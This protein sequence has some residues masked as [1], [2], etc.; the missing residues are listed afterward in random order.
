MKKV[1]MLS[2]LVTTCLYLI[3]C[4]PTNIPREYTIYFDSK[5]GSDVEPIKTD[6]KS[7]IT[8]PE[9]PEKSGYVF[10]GWYWDDETFDDPLTVNSFLDNPISSNMTVYA[11]WDEN[12]E[13]I[14]YFAG[15]K[16]ENTYQFSLTIDA[17]E[18]PNYSEALLVDIKP[19]PMH[20]LAP[21]S[22]TI[23]SGEQGSRLIDG[24]LLIDEIVA[25][26][27]YRYYP[28]VTAGPY[29]FI[30][31]VNQVVTLEIDPLFKGDYNGQLPT[32]E[33]IIQKQ[34]D[35]VTNVQQVINGEI[36]LVAGVIEGAMIEAAEAASTV[37]THY[38]ERNGYGLLAMTCDFG[39]TTDVKVRQAIAHLTDRDYLIQNILEG[40]ASEIYS[41]YSL[42]QWMFKESE[43]WALESLNPYAFNIDAANALLDETI[44]R[45]ESDGET[46]WDKAKA[47]TEENYYRYNSSG[48]VLEIRHFQ[49]EGG[50]NS[51]PVSDR[52]YQ[53]MPL[54]GIQYQGSFGSFDTLIDHYYYGFELGD[55]RIYH[56][57]N[58][59]TNFDNP[60]D[61]Y[62]SWHS[63]LLNTWYNCQGL[64]DED[65]DELMM[66]LRE[67]DPN[68]ETAHADYLAAWRAYQ[69]RW[70][71]LIPS[72]PLYSNQYYQV[73]DISLEGVD[74]TTAFAD[75]SK[76]ICNIN[77][78]ADT[79]DD[80]LIVGVM[81]MNGNYMPGFG[82]NEYDEQIRNLIYGYGT[83]AVTPGG[84]IILNETVVE[85][86]EI[87][88]NDDFSKTYT[89][90][91][92]N[93]LF[94]SDG[95]PITAADFVFAVLFQASN[96]WQDITN[97][98]VGVGLK[99]YEEYR[100]INPVS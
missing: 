57:F 84:E 25:P 77:W 85:D 93:D 14:P 17:A 99:G 81:E 60:Y 23:E 76:S 38:V 80:E 19:L 86:L 68:S 65:L 49:T 61:P 64:D 79:D 41:E 63:D 26:G 98:S 70:N 7:A 52:F 54:A 97:S 75:W 2:W 1:L 51:S 43:Q 94:W 90:T 95:E 28:A 34:V 8:L 4:H 10:G 13:V 100:D 69:V 59:A 78:A 42:E 67:I 24:F 6:G 91:I 16:L 33:T 44:W 3:S 72:V 45:F 46:P 36:D 32:I 88:V 29:K 92:A 82:S 9:D 11:K 53:T 27:G 31:F 56:L 37:G 39:P 5:G 20:V 66:E 83:Y 18:F 71:H 89:F 22:A 87:V 96:E 50:S 74:K 48:E 58:L 47:A 55:E 73:F 12:T 15:V 21:D 62:F 40:Y 35:P 30:S